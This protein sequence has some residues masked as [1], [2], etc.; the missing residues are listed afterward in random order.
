VLERLFKI[1]YEQEKHRLRKDFPVDAELVE[2]SIEITKADVTGMPLRDLFKRYD[3][4]VVFGRIFRRGETSLAHWDTALELGDTIMLVGSE[5][6][7]KRVENDLGNSSD[8]NLAYDRTLFDRRRIFVSNPEVAGRSIASLNLK[9]KY[10]AI[11]TRIRRGDMDMLAKSD[12]VLEMGDR[13]RFI[14]RRE[15]LK[16]LSKYFGDSYRASSTIN[17]FSF[18]LGIGLGLLL[19]S[20]EFSFGPNFSF[21]LGYAGG[22][23]IVGL[24]LGALRRTGPVLWTLPYSANVTLQQLGLM[25]LLAAIGVRSGSA[26]VQSFTVEGLWVFLASAIISLVTAFLIIIIGY[27]ILKKPF[28]LLMGMV[29][30]QPAILDFATARSGNTIPVFGFSLMF[31]IALISKIVIA[32]ILFA[33]LN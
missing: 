2:A 14:A 5:E 29:A 20:V 28:T 18:G 9:E 33:L 3:W 26:F 27:K 21:T 25:L 12:M 24:I 16:A 8:S 7:V 15:D 32:Q 13:I 11:I 4:N 23:L 30:N 6:E 10:N 22:P 17:I 31:P 19:G 1:D